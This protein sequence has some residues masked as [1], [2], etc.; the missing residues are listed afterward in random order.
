LPE[1]GDL[2]KCV[3]NYRKCHYTN[4]VM[5]Y[6]DDYDDY[7]NEAIRYG[8]REIVLDILSRQAQIR[9]GSFLDYVEVALKSQQ[10]HIVGL[11]L[12]RQSYD[13][14]KILELAV[15]SGCQEIMDRMLKD[16]ATR[17]GDLAGYAGASGDIDMIKKVFTLLT[18][19]DANYEQCLRGTIRY[20]RVEAFDYLK[21]IRPDLVA[22][23][24]RKT[25][26]DELIYDW[27]MVKLLLAEGATVR[28]EMANSFLK[29]PDFIEVISMPGFRMDNFHTNLLSLSIV[30]CNYE[31]FDV[32]LP[33]MSKER[34]SD[35]QTLENAM[36]CNSTYFFHQ[37]LSHFEFSTTQIVYV[38]NNLSH[39]P[40]ISPYFFDVLFRRFS[41]GFTRGDLRRM[42]DCSIALS[43]DY[44]FYKVCDR[45]PEAD[46][47]QG[48]REAYRLGKWEYFE[49]LFTPTFHRQ[50]FFLGLVGYPKATLP[51]KI[52]PQIFTAVAKVVRSDKSLEMAYTVSMTDMI[53]ELNDE[54]MI[55]Q[56]IRLM[57]V[58]HSQLITNIMIV[59]LFCVQRPI[60]EDLMKKILGTGLIDH[61]LLRVILSD[62]YKSYPHKE[63]HISRVEYVVTQLSHMNCVAQML[64]YTRFDFDTS[65]NDRVRVVDI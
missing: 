55:A 19:N 36:R 64:S 22:D 50:G 40:K 10:I 24:I 6:Q 30:C 39:I 3:E 9:P 21:S 13:V 54:S 28:P 60:F 11:L 15:R 62:D 57:L 65:V 49:H 25:S 16:G 38:I 41:Q 17:F 51:I 58:D 48:C 63:D 20:G 56:Y 5:L 26:F 1:T 7:I 59:A 23:Y 53:S 46:R 42:L 14:N 12:D 18:D 44:L 4:Q 27:N 31:V 2:G 52:D 37:L 43:L 35:Y 29:K 61:C 8:H 45:C 32:L 34:P 47:H 33:R